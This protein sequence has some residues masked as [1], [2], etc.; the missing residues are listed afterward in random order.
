[1]EF[2]FIWNLFCQFLAK[3]ES[4]VVRIW[5]LYNC[6]SDPEEYEPAITGMAGGGE[7]LEEGLCGGG[8]GLLCT[9][10]YQPLVVSLHLSSFWKCDPD[11]WRKMRLFP[12]HFSSGELGTYK[13]VYFDSPPLVLLSS[14]L[15]VVKGRML[16]GILKS[17][18]M[19][20]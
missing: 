6:L 12:L 16:W 5:N 3:K 2:L 1:M 17:C 4:V 10:L 15:M 9:M 13:W 18:H 7:R 11:Q 14:A 8:L 19:T 20:E